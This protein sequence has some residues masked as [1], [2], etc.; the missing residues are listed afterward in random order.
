MKNKFERTIDRVLSIGCYVVVFGCLI[1]MIIEIAHATE[2]YPATW[3]DIPEVMDEPEIE[4]SPEPVIDIYEEPEEEI[5]IQEAVLETYKQPTMEEVFGYDFDKVVRVVTAEAGSDPELCHAIAQCISN[6]CA[7]EG[8]IYTPE[9]ILSEYRYCNPRDFTTEE[10]YE[11]CVDI[12][13]NGET[14]EP[15]GNALYMYAPA[16]C[17]SDW[18]ES[19]CY[20]TTI[21][22]IRF[23]TEWVR[24]ED[25]FGGNF[26]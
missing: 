2:I 15:V 19:K 21:S 5:L 18:H 23:F 26:R 20:V 3:T 8:Y 17:E 10:A 16:I 14:Y 1:G 25:G 7:Y 12:F 6:A 11:A 22:G 4:L 13:I 9:E 24:T